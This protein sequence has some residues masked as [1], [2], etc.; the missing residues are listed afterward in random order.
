MGDYM[1][2]WMKL[3]IESEANL[4][5]MIAERDKLRDHNKH[6]EAELARLERLVS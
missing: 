6:L 3:F 1:D 2:M 4:K 5:E